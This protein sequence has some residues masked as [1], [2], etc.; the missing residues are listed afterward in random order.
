MFSFDLNI[1][2]ILAPPDHVQCQTA[3]KEGEWKIVVGGKG[4]GKERWLRCRTI[5]SMQVMVDIVFILPEPSA[6][7]CVE[8][9]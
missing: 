2:E 5:A 4:E 6:L 9:V 1:K 7:Q 3:R 8:I